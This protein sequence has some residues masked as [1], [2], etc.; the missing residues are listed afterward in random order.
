MPYSEERWPQDKWGVCMRVGSRTWLRSGDRREK[1]SGGGQV[2]GGP[3]PVWDPVV[4]MDER[5]R[6][7]FVGGGKMESEGLV[8]ERGVGA[9]SLMT[10]W[11]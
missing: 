8:G 7:H 5:Q 10:P 6:A 1:A 3:R 11:V 4:K 9:V 2:A